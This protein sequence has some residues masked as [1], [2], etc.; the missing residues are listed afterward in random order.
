VK[1][2]G[3]P[4]SG[5]PEAIPGRNLRGQHSVQQRRCGRLDSPLGLDFTSYRRAVACAVRSVVLTGAEADALIK[6]REHVRSLDPE[7]DIVE[8]FKANLLYL[9]A[10]TTPSRA[11][12]VAQWTY[13]DPK[14]LQRAAEDIPARRA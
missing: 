11:R 8:A 1:E 3:R 9:A 10:A 13:L 7:D 12:G 14:A 4:R 6:V 5:G 2:R